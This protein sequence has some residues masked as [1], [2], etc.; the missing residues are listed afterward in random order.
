MM[1]ALLSK[2]YKQSN[3]NR[4]WMYRLF[5]CVKNYKIFFKRTLLTIALLCFVFQ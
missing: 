1:T 4:Q 2:D 3:V 5:V